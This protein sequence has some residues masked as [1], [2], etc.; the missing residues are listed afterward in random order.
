MSGM[1][2]HSLLRVQYRLIPGPVLG[3]GAREPNQHHFYAQGCQGQ[4]RGGAR[5]EIPKEGL[6]KDANVT[7]E[8]WARRWTQQKDRLCC[9]GRTTYWIARGGDSAGTCGSNVQLSCRRARKEIP[10][11][12]NT[13]AKAG[14]SWQVQGNGMTPVD[15]RV[16]CGRWEV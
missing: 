1:D 4:G 2:F 3:V 14:R 9:R 15:W 5:K 6:Q 10:G 7:P 8:N 11:S 12:V 13:H 16:A